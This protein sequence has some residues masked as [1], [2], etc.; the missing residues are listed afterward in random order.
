MPR[1]RVRKK[2]TVRRQTNL[3]ARPH[4]AATDHSMCLRC[5]HHWPCP[6]VVAGI[7]LPKD[8]PCN[9]VPEP[10][11]KWLT[12]RVQ[13]TAM[14]LVR[15]SGRRERVDGELHILWVVNPRVAPFMQD[16]RVDINLHGESPAEE[17]IV[18]VLGWL[19][20]QPPIEAT[21]AEL[22]ATCAEDLDLDA[23]HVERCLFWAQ[24]FGFVDGPVG[25]A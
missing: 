23:P 1:S 6:S 18:K 7:D 5:G 14:D 4:R 17:D 3:V 12:A 15:D 13:L 20:G 2:R 24:V 25:A 22:A 16:V 8:V 21:R 19:Y 10:E 11:S 9:T